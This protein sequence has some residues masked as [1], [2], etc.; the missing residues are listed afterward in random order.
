MNE[1]GRANQRQRTRRDLLSAAARLMKEGQCPT[2]AEVAEE[3]HV[4]RA[5]AYRYFPSQDVLLTE[6]PIERAVP[7]PEDLFSD[8]PSTDPEERIDKA[9][10]ILHKMVYANESQLRVM[11]AKSLERRVRRHKHDG[12]PVRQNRRG[13][14]IAAALQPARNRFEDSTYELLQAA[15][16]CFLGTESMVVFTD[17]LQVNQRKARAVKRWATRALVRAALEE[18]RRKANSRSRRR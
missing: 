9:E 1:E 3:A 14:L 2:V 11:L 13:P 8:D 17:V 15:L 7:T 10:R 16:A 5:T 4:S 18:S 12:T 6:A